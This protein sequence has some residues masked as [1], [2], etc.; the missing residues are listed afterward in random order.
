MFGLPSPRLRLSMF[1]F[2]F[3]CWPAA[4]PMAQPG[5]PL[6]LGLEHNIWIN[7]D[8]SFSTQFRARS[9]QT[10]AGLCVKLTALS[11]CFPPPPRQRHEYSKL[12][13]RVF[14]A[15]EMHRISRSTPAARP[16]ITIGSSSISGSPRLILP[17]RIPGCEKKLVVRSSF[18][19][20]MMCTS[21]PTTP[22]DP[23]PVAAPP[24]PT[25]CLSFSSG[26]VFSPRLLVSSSSSSLVPAE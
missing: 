25:F 16:I 17:A 8:F 15:R 4:G 22:E 1:L 14:L 18:L 13:I 9:R 12:F 24:A 23:V 7:G 26:Y 11:F 6:R 3:I 2:C 19:A 21:L 10:S 20:F 5:S